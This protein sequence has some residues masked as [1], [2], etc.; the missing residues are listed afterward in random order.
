MAYQNPK[1][2]FLF[3][4]IQQSEKWVINSLHWLSQGSGYDKQLPTVPALHE[5]RL[6]SGVD[7]G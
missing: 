2:L 5:P 4:F 7:M 1:F 6:E 3:N